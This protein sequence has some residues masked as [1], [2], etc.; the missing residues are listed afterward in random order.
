LKRIPSI[1]K[2]AKRE[3]RYSSA[4]SLSAPGFTASLQVPSIAGVLVTPQTALTFTAWYAAQRVITEDLSSLPFCTFRHLEGGGSKIERDYPVSTL[5]NWSPDGET[6]DLNWREAY[7]GHVFGWGNGYSE[8]EWDSEGY[9]VRLHMDHPSVVLPKRDSRGSLFYEIQANEQAGGSGATRYRK[10]P[11]WDM[12]HF[13]GMSFNALVGYAPVA[14]VREGI[15]LGK[16]QEQFDAAAMGN[17]TIPCGV[18]EYPGKMTDEARAN[19]R[20][21]WNLVHQ[22]S[23]AAHKIA[24]LQQG[25]KFVANHISPEMVQ[26]LASRQFQV[27]E[28]CRIW[29]LP[30][31][32]LADFTTAHLANLETANDDYIIS[33]LRPW[34]IRFEKCI[35]FKL[36]GRDGFAKG[37]YTKH[38]FRPLLLTLTKDRADFYRKL[39]EIGVYTVNEIRELEGLNPI[40]TADG[41]EL[42]FKPVNVMGLTEKHSD[43]TFNK[44]GKDDGKDDGKTTGEKTPRGLE[45]IMLD[46]G[47]LNGHA[48]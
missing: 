35:N 28:I 32:K 15:G 10:V 4:A 48:A 47:V 33:C 6:T 19:L 41:G 1:L 9:P 30:P 36:I 20:N 12:L 24:I 40:P 26:L 34:A 13:A 23:A 27:I 38:D 29:R 44:S 25:V 3:A 7:Y 39:W 11:P 5:F 2:R 17:G 46:R 8:I 21:E 42:R 37:L 16:A 22:G 14:L 43:M 18:L 31:H 45:E